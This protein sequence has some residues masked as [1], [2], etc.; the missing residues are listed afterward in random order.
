MTKYTL[1]RHYF[2]N[3]LNFYLIL[4]RRILFNSLIYHH[5]FT[6]VLL[7]TLTS[8]LLFS[9]SKAK[10]DTIMQ[11]KNTLIMHSQSLIQNGFHMTQRF[12]FLFSTRVWM[13]WCLYLFI[14]SFIK[15]L[16]KVTL[17]LSTSCA[18]FFQFNVV[19]KTVEK[20]PI[21]WCSNC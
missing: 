21:V 12:I 14:P 7:N 1:R 15:R 19:E 3:L 8:L 18:T 9:L 16:N 11:H 2:I 5:T 4:S 10:Q 6:S 13:I 17:P 20:Y